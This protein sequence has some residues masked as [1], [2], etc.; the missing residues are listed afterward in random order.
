MV[1]T[2]YVFE[3]IDV[4]SVLIDRFSLTFVRCNFMFVI[5]NE[6]IHISMQVAVTF[7][8]HNH[9]GLEIFCPNRDVV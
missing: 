8:K 6:Y 7:V 4:N 1:Y 3:L 5:Y 9:L 2:I